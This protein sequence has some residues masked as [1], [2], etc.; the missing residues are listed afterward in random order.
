MKLSRYNFLKQIDDVTIFFNSMTCALAV[1]DENFLRAYHELENGSFKES[2]YDPKLIKDMH[3]SGCILEDDA[4]ELELIE[5]F[6]NVGKYDNTNLALT[7]APTLDCNF[8]CEYCFENHRRGIMDESTQN[9]LVD[10]VREKM[11]KSRSLNVT[12]YGG[13][14]LMTRDIVYSLSERFLKIC[15]ECNSKYNAA[16]VTNASLFRDSDI[17]QF[18]KYHIEMAQITIDGPKE[19][20][21]KRRKTINGTSTFDHIIDVVNKLANENFKI[22]VR[23]N[24]DR[25]NISYVEDLLKILRD[26]VK[27]FSA[28]RINFGQVTSQNGICRSIEDSCYNSE[29]YA[30]VMLP[31]Y[32]KVLQYGFTMSKMNIYPRAKFNY[33]CADYIN[34]FVIDSDGSIYKCWN[35]VGILDRRS[36]H[37]ADHSQIPQKNFLSWIR[38]NPLQVEKCRECKFL[39]ICMGG[40]PEMSRQNGNGEPICDTIKFNIDKVLEFYYR[41]LKRR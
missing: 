5:Y 17:D 23:I 33:C 22:V 19:I 18:K 3:S 31:L 26:R 24:I 38:Y 35:I 6:R 29:Q 4:D 30:N 10:F 11:K 2:D 40:C 37:I 8:R 25:E 7:I 32:E 14:P 36:G 27:N 13:E 15:D 21:D 1:V 34:S 12:W 28:V 16:I 39:P 9:L 41:N 20:H